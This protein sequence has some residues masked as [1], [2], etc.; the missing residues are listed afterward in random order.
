V[1]SLVAGQ[2]LRA[3]DLNVVDEL[4]VCLEISGIA[5]PSLRPLCL[6]LDRDQQILGGTEI[7]HRGR[8]RSQCGGV[9]L[10]GPAAGVAPFQ[11]RLALVSPEIE[12]LVFAIGIIGDNRADPLDAR[13]ILA[14]RVRIR[15]GG[16][17][18]AEYTF[19]GADFDGEK[20]ICLLE[21]YRKAGWRLAVTHGGFIGG[22]PTL[23]SSYR[24]NADM[25]TLIAATGPA[26]APECAPP[27]GI[28]LPADWPGR[29]EPAIPTGLAPSVG[30]ILASDQNGETGCGTG[31]VISPAGLVLTCSHVV[32][33]S[34]HSRFV[35]AGTEEVRDV[36][37][38]AASSDADVALLR[39]KADQGSTDWIRIADP[40]HEP[41]L[42]DPVGILGYPLGLNLGLEI[43]YCE[44][45]VNSVRCAGDIRVLQIDA[46]AAP[47]SSGSPVFQR[48]T[49]RVIGILTSGLHLKTGGMHVNFA[50]DVRTIWD[51]GWFQRS[52]G[53]S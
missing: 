24:A 42:G 39:M 6:C 40:G 43:S 12:R 18:V 52:D 3:E 25:T 19:R 27:R 14:G 31:F 28:R 21:L 17:D 13:R 29:V 7:V 35:L 5:P 8:D 4:E 26:V 16:E 11:I 23:L 36:E 9:V 46:G 37:L 50:V 53:S 49:G 32:R 30:M 45:I 22:I 44:G 41:G 20:A 47:G 48:G 1:R 38:L 15:S 2:R 33:Q 10:S 51:F 34:A